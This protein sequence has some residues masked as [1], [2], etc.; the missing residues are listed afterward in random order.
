ME[1]QEWRPRVVF[2]EC[3]RRGPKLGGFLCVNPYGRNRLTR[4]SF[5][6]VDKTRLTSLLNTDESYIAASGVRVQ[7]LQGI[8]IYSVSN[9]VLFPIL[10][11]ETHGPISTCMFSC[12]STSWTVDTVISYV[13]PFLRMKHS[14]FGN[15]SRVILMM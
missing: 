2:G 4:F 7:P 1:P 14:V 3:Q 13:F 8:Q 12:S 15:I 5:N 10:G 6:D 9:L 11:H